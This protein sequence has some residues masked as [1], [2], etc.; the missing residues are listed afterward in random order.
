M[1][2]KPPQ[3]ST[4]YGLASWLQTGSQTAPPEHA[5]KRK[6]KA[7]RQ[8]SPQPDISKTAVEISSPS[9]T[10]GRT[11]IERVDEH[12]T[13]SIES[14]PRTGPENGIAGFIEPD[15]LDAEGAL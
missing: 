6:T 8:D 4:A 1:L 3:V 7:R 14:V 10:P 2:R 15:R 5:M 9:A 11:S 12:K 13:G